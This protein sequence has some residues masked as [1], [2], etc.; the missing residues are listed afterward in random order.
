MSVKES[1]LITGSGWLSRTLSPELQTDAPGIRRD[2]AAV[3]AALTLPD[4]NGLLE[5]HIKRLK[6]I[7]RSMYGRAKFDLV[8]LRGLCAA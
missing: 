3:H 1:G 2:Y 6:L 5:G 4:S 8:R 7:K